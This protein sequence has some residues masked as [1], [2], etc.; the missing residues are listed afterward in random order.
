MVQYSSL[1]FQNSICP[2]HWP[3]RDQWPH[4][5]YFLGNLSPILLY[6][7]IIMK[8]M[9][10]TWQLYYSYHVWM[11]MLIKGKIC[12]AY[13]KPLIIWTWPW[14]G[15]KKSIVFILRNRGQIS[16][17][18]ICFYSFIELYHSSCCYFPL[19]NYIFVCDCDLHLKHFNKPLQLIKWSWI[20]YF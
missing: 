13:I 2:V 3:F 10:I 12:T 6:T 17:H 14:N 18:I 16:R 4:Y 8:Q 9:C 20:V 15:Y 19:S 5:Y 7:E 1:S 11:I